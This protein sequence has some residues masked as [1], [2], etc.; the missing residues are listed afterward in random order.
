MQSPKSLKE[1]RKEFQNNIVI[2]SK[3]Q[4]S[5]LHSKKMLSA[6]KYIFRGGNRPM[7]YSNILDEV[8]S[9]LQPEDLP[10][11]Y[12]VLVK[13]IDLQGVER[14]LRGDDLEKFM[15][16][17]NKHLGIAEAR[18][19][20]DI[21]KIRAAIMTA[22]NVFFADLKTAIDEMPPNPLQDLE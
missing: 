22:V 9:G 19:I 10:V 15:N 5:G 3:I 1:P 18:V 13:I 20:L 8:I 4:Q 12:I 17:P 6:N 16:D 21:R 14:N 2:V 11:E 7:S